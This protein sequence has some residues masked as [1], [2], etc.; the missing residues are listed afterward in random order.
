M[1]PEIALVPVV[2]RKLSDAVVEQLRHMLATGQ[3][4]PGDTLPSER[5]MMARMGVGRPAVRDALQHLHTQGVITI[6]HG[7]RSRVNELNPELALHQINDIADLLIAVAP[8]NLGHLREARRMF[9]VGVVRQAAQRSRS[10]DV[11]RL[12]LL[13]KAQRDAHGDWQAFMRADIAFH[14]SIAEILGNP[15]VTALSRGMLGWLFNHHTALLHWSG[16]ENITLAEHEGLI[17]ALAAQDA[18]LAADLMAAHLD[19]SER[20]YRKEAQ[21]RPA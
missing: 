9:E 20:F 4:K 18:E 3:L 2:R 8:E 16:H 5:E 13:V 7:E 10:E 6:S 15:V 14:A 1:K 12:R 19:R 11:E 17:E 21:D